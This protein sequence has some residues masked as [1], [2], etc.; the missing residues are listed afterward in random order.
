ML[1]LLV[2]CGES[3]TITL[4]EVEGSGTRGT[5]SVHEAVGKSFTTRVDAFVEVDAPAPGMLAGLVKGT[6][7]APGAVLQVLQVHPSGEGGAAEVVVPE[8]KLSDLAGHS[9]AV[10][11]GEP[12]ASQRLACG[13]L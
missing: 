6:C 12:E 11:A 13:D 2:G 7:A 4:A 5:V 3:K 1:V 10:F 9:I 8:G